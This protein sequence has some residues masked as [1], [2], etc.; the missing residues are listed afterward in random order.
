MKFLDGSTRK[1]PRLAPIGVSQ[2]FEKDDDDI[3]QKKG[4]V[5]SSAAEETVSKSTKM[6]RENESYDLMTDD[7]HATHES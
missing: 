2:L 5:D 7:K 3:E 1:T 4:S 6:S